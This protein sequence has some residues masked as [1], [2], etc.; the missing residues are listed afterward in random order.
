MERAPLSVY[1][2]FWLNSFQHDRCTYLIRFITHC[3]IFWS[4]YKLLYVL[5]YI[6]MW[7]LLTGRQLV[8]V[9]K[10]TQR[11]NWC[12]CVSGIHLLAHLAFGR[13]LG[14]SD[15]LSW[16]CQYGLLCFFSFNV[17]SLPFPSFP[18]PPFSLSLFFSILSY[19]NGQSSQHTSM[20]IMLYG[21]AFF[22]ISN[23]CIFKVAILKFGIAL[24]KRDTKLRCQN[25]F[26]LWTNYSVI[27]RLWDLNEVA[28]VF[29]LLMFS[30]PWGWAQ[31]LETQ[32][33]EPGCLGTES[34]TNLIYVPQIKFFLCTLV[35]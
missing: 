17:P 32:T 13:A 27:C 24:G 4:N 9:H 3:F 16:I 33:S 12:F 25:K 28:F 26:S 21:W 34:R 14:L 29:I 10:D 5:N 11:Y 31:R 19:C 7:S 18:F 30:H 8:F 35:S 1:F 2:D 22:L 20:S 23:H 15:R 6:S